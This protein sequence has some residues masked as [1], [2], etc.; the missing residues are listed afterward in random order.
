[1]VHGDKVKLRDLVFRNL[2][3]NA[4]HYTEHG[5]IRIEL[6]KNQHMAQCRVIDSGVGISKEDMSKLFTPGGHGSHAQEINPQSSG[7]GLADAKRL[8]EM[9]E[10]TIS[11]Y[12]DGVH[13]GSMFAVT[14][15]LET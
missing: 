1:M 2:I 3:D 12:S 10:G 14:L 11:A 9:H 13:Q 15:P 8:V 7:Y 6:V 5:F 4:I